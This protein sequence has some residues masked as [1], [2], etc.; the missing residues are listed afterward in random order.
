MSE[1]KGGEYTKRLSQ[2][3]RSSLYQRGQEESLWGNEHMPP[4]DLQVGAPPPTYSHFRLKLKTYYTTFLSD[5]LRSQIRNISC[6]CHPFCVIIMIFHEPSDNINILI[7]GMHSNPPRMWYNIMLLIY[8]HF[9][10]KTQRFLFFALLMTCHNCV[11]NYRVIQW[12]HWWLL[13][14]S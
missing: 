3:L 12:G 11:K 4:A 8:P 10:S 1:D 14:F 7:L 2:E 5:L 9:Y 6:Y 13:S